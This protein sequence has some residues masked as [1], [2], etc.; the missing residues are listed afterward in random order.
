MK[1]AILLPLSLLFAMMLVAT[2]ACAHPA[3]V[4][5]V[6]NEAVDYI[7]M[8]VDCPADTIEVMS[9]AMGRTIKN[10]VTL[11]IDFFIHDV[12]AEGIRYPVLYLLHG[13]YGC[14]SDWPKKAD[15]HRLANEY[16]VIIVCGQLV[17]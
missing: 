11:P 15:L 4:K 14:Y 2:S 1:K 9:Q 3:P 7:D 16:K 13:A 10:V 5:D 8:H 6:A 17:F 12:E